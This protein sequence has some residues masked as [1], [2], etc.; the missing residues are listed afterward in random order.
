MLEEIWTQVCNIVQ[1]AVTKTISKK[2]KHKKA[3]WLCEEAL[4]IAKKR[5]EEKWKAN[6]KGKD[7]PNWMQLSV[8]SSILSNSLPPNEL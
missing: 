8:S 4:Q 2:N 7:A 6:E 1:E 5:K 3:K